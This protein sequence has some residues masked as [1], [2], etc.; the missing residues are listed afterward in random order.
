MGLRW[1]FSGSKIESEGSKRDISIQ[2]LHTVSIYIY[3][4]ASDF[5]NLHL[6]TLQGRGL[7]RNY[8]YATKAVQCQAKQGVNQQRKRKSVA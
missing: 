3:P 4:Q 7:S 8:S 2:S 5:L 6:V 1:P